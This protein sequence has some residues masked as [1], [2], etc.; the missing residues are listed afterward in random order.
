VAKAETLVAALV[1]D[2]ASRT[3]EGASLEAAA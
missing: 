3:A 2:F 1:A